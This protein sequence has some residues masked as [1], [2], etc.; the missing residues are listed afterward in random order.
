[1]GIWCLWTVFWGEGSSVQ[2]GL[3][4]CNSGLKAFSLRVQEVQGVRI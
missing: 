2:I 1:M 3:W 4:V